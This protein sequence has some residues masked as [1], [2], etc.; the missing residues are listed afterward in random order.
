MSDQEMT[1]SIIGH[2]SDHKQMTYLLG[3][4]ANWLHDVLVNSPKMITNLLQ[5]YQS[6]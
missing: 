1:H 2:S 4:H 6:W 3:P 5:D